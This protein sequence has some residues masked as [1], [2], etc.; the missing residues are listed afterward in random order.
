[1]VAVPQ[2][3]E[4]VDWYL[5]YISSVQSVLKSQIATVLQ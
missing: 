1:M 2:E 4:Q 3:E 5:I